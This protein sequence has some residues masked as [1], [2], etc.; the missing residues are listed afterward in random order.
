MPFKTVANNASLTF[1]EFYTLITEIE[2]I[3]N[4]RSLIPISTD[5]NDLIPLTSAHFLI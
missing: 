5:P 1:E 4:S 2:A 3:L